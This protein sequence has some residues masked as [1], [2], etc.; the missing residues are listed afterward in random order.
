VIVCCLGVVCLSIFGLLATGDAAVI[1]GSIDLSEKIE[2]AIIPTAGVVGMWS[3][4]SGL[5]GGFAMQLIGAARPRK[6]LIGEMM[7]SIIAGVFL[8]AFIFDGMDQSS[9]VVMLKL[10]GLC[11]VA[12]VSGSVV[13]LARA[14]A[15]EAKIGSA[16]N[17]VTGDKK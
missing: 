17:A 6:Q 13:V 15:L 2:Q 14:K 8:G 16:V 5:F 3:A 7:M 12:G 9:P 10:S 11:A 1:S 4:S